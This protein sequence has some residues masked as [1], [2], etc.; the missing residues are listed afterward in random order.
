MNVAAIG[1]CSAGLRITELPAASAA[2]TM[3]NTAVGPFHGMIRPTTPI[4]S[5]TW[6]TLNS[7]GTAGTAPCSLDGQPEKYSSPSTANWTMNPV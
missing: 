5:R 3:A 4:G 7:L 1:V 6:Y 2:A